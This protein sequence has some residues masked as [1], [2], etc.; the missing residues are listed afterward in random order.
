MLL[1][2]RSPPTIMKQHLPVIIMSLSR[3]IKG[4]VVLE[5]LKKYSIFHVTIRPM[6]FVG[7]HST[8]VIKLLWNSPSSVVCMF[9]WSSI[10]KVRSI[11]FIQTASELRLCICPHGYLGWRSQWFLNSVRAPMLQFWRIINEYVPQRRVKTSSRETEKLVTWRTMFFRPWQTSLWD[12]WVTLWTM[13]QVLLP[14]G[15]CSA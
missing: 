12:A 1:Y 4:N 7:F 5:F 9:T 13:W 10:K 2:P 15:S 6:C 3:K 14:M 11:N 8:F